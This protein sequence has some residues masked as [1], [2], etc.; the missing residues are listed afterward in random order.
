MNT[1]FASFCFPIVESACVR[2]H[3]WATDCLYTSLNRHTPE[4]PQR[5]GG[6]TNKQL[7]L[8]SLRLCGELVQSLALEVFGADLQLLAGAYE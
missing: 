2:V 7:S 8:R 4:V 3:P 6:F 5:D 1:D